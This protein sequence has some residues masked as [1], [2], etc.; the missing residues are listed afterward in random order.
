MEIV[1]PVL[2]QIELYIFP[3]DV[4]KIKTGHKV[5]I[6]TLNSWLNSEAFVKSVGKVV[7]NER[8]SINCYAGLKVNGS[9]DLIINQL[10]D[11]EIIT[12]EEALPALPKDAVLKSDS[13]T[14]V[15]LLVKTEDNKY[16][17]TKKRFRPALSRMGLYRLLEI[18]LRE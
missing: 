13:G 3:D 12:G 8:K 6:K 18:K 16:I 17:F 14:F 2:I 5:R 7:D 9:E 4:S 11:S 15:L 10:V 1:N